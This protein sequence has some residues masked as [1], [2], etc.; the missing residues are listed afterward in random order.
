MHLSQ[1]DYLVQWPFMLGAGGAYLAM[2]LIGKAL[3]SL[4]KDPVTIPKIFPILYNIVQV[5]SLSYNSF[6]IQNSF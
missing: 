2:C 3:M 5:S 4:K 1:Y 6:S